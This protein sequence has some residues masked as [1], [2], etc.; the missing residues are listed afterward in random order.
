MPA[1]T[2]AKALMTEADQQGHLHQGNSLFLY[3]GVQN[4]ERCNICW[5]VCSVAAR[6]IL[7]FAQ[8]QSGFYSFFFLK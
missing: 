1:Q 5:T 8:Q 6:N 4:S 2:V 7:Q 3:G